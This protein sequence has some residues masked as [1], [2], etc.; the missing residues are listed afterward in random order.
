MQHSWV[1]A[2]QSVEQTKWSQV[3]VQTAVNPLTVSFTRTLAQVTHRRP[4]LTPSQ[5]VRSGDSGDLL[6][7]S[8][9]PPPVQAEQADNPYSSGSILQFGSAFCQLRPVAARLVP[10][11]ATEM[12]ETGPARAKQIRAY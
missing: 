10:P 5:K 11:S 1:L 8:S 2:H 6:P 9:C 3:C 12:G 4:G 7:G